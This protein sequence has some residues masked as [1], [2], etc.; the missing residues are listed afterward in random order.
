MLNF[1]NMPNILIYTLNCK[2]RNT[3][4]KNNRDK[5]NI[6]F[7]YEQ[8]RNYYNICKK[9]WDVIYMETGNN[10]NYSKDTIDL[11]K[12][13]NKVKCGPLRISS[14]CIDYFVDVIQLSFRNTPKML[15][16]RE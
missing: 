13:I 8:I 7:Y 1:Q 16:V 3:D 5:P 10:S 9:T 11:I 12:R 6:S 2:L 14:F 15:T 4:Y